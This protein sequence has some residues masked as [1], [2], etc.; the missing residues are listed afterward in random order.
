MST[1]GTEP[2]VSLLNCPFFNLTDT[3]GA[4]EEYVEVYDGN[5]GHQKFCGTNGPINLSAFGGLRDLYIKYKTVKRDGLRDAEE[6]KV[7][8]FTCTVS[9]SQR[10]TTRPPKVPLPNSITLFHLLSG[11]GTELQKAYVPKV[12]PLCCK[13]RPP[14]P[15]PSSPT[16]L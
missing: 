13:T 4:C 2:C 3:Q 15:P 14:L 5:K 8:K 10:G 1:Q 6:E 11:D 16:H 7:K 9:C 12:N